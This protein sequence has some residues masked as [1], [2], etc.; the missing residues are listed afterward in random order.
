[1]VKE[2]LN[3]SKS[4]FDAG[5]QVQVSTEGVLLTFPAGEAVSAHLYVLSSVCA[6]SSCIT[7]ISRKK[8]KSVWPPTSCSCCDNVVSN[9]SNLPKTINCDS[10]PLARHER[11]W[12]VSKESRRHQCPTFTVSPMNKSITWINNHEA[13]NNVHPCVFLQ[14]LLNIVIDWL[15]KERKSSQLFLKSDVL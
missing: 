7:E 2:V 10:C 12:D 13:G 11:P 14:E 9:I 4:F 1:M 15:L 3:T 8:D 5:V 6:I